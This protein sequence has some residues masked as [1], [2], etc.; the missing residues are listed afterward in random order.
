[1]R[2]PRVWQ[3]LATAAALAI[4]GSVS[5]RAGDGRTLLRLDPGWR[6]YAGDDPHAQETAFNDSSW[7]PVDLPHTWNA[8]DGQ[9]GGANYRR[10]P[11]W[12]RRHLVPDA[13]LAG[14]R[15]YLQFDG[16]S[17]MADVY[18]N[19]VHLGTHKG[20]FARFRFDATAALKVGAD[21]VIAVRVDNG[22]L[23]I[24]P[25]SADFTFFGGLY[26]DVGLL[27]TD[28]VQISTMDHG[29]PGVFLE[30]HEVSASSAKILVRME[31]EN[32]TPAP[33][34]VDVC[35]SVRD[36]TGATVG[37][38]A[39]FRTHLEGG[40]Q[41]EVLKPVSIDRPHLWS[42]RADPYLYSVRVA[43]SPVAENGAPGAV[44][45]AVEQPLGLR[46]YT[47][48]PDKGFFLNGAYLNLYGFNR[49][50]DWPDKGWA[51]SDADEAEDFALMM[52]SG[53]TAVRVS[54]YQQSDSW[55]G[56]CD[57]GGIVAWAEIPFVNQALA[58]PEFVDNARQ[59]LR[60]L[61]RQNFNHP[62]ICFWGVGNET[63]GEAAPGVVAALA[64]VVREEDP[65]RLST[66]ASHHD[67]ADPRNW[68][69]DVVGFNRYFG[70][71]RGELSDFPAWLDRTHADY[72][73]ARFGMSEYG[74]GASIH[75]HTSSPAR[76][77][78]RGPWHPEEYQN[79][80][81][82]AYWAALR[83]RPYVWGKFIWCLHDFASDGRNEGEQPGRNDKGLVTYD[84]KV[85]K[86]AFYF[87]Q[88]QWTTQPVLHLTGSRFDPRTEAVTEVKVY[89]NAPRVEVFVNGASQG[90]QEDPSG[91]RVFRWPSVRLAA[92]ENRVQARARFG[93]TE[94]SDACVWTLV[95][96]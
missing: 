35:V 13:S 73:K 21:N 96:H 90:V 62:S 26:R 16:A 93:D 61:I 56:R 55:Y 6:F 10:G 38:D 12:Y 24:P 19:G 82:E 8:Q 11:G 33:R 72:P 66:Y 87:Y 54:H 95:A 68:R 37:K 39:T 18:V 5:V 40:G 32:H 34:E 47:V 51:I 48:D 86:D 22:A 67:N 1:M 71:Y 49:H 79:L 77:D 84:R 69:T 63:S 91:E 3:L 88:A 28:P 83:T 78:P 46:S 89:S 64:P 31:I 65:T 76:P 81:H 29:S 58:T 14:R 25:T 80:Y 4:G 92:G 36:A 9:D 15:L 50:Q 94:R 53:A 42:G 43:L 17:L 70:W 60:E 85:R 41:R 52:E 45:D 57:K 44:S 27:A 20:G 30:Q 59:Q 74:A 23:G 75:Q 7:Q 2:R